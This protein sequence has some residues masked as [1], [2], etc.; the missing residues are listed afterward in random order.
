MDLGHWSQTLRHKRSHS[1]T[2]QSGVTSYV[3]TRDRSTSRSCSHI[4]VKTY[5][6][7]R[8]ICGS[9][10]LMSPVTSEEFLGHRCP[11]LR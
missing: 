5:D 4:R 7:Q 6:L 1:V 8:M 11:K 10:I 9:D 2:S 3:R